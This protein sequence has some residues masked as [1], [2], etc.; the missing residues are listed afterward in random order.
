MSLIQLLLGGGSKN[1]DFNAEYLVVEV[2]GVLLVVV[3]VV[4]AGIEMVLPFR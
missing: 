4:L 2:R 3:V 1:P